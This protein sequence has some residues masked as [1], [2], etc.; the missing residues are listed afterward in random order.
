VSI[1]K[2]LVS[3]FLRPSLAELQITV[4]DTVVCEY[5]LL[6]HYCLL[7]KSM[8]SESLDATSL[9]VVAQC[10]TMDRPLLRLTHDDYTVACICPMGVE[11]APVE[12]MLD[13]MHQSLPASRDKNSYTLGRIGAHNVVIAV[14]PEIG[15]N[16]AAIVATQLL[17]DFTSIRFGLLVG[18]GGGIPGDDE[19]DIR[20]GDVVVSKP[21]ATFGGVVQFD[22]GK[23]HPNGQF[24][25]TGTL[26]KPPAVL[27]ANVQRLEAQ[28][29]RIGNQISKYL[30]EMLERFPNMEEEYLHP[31]M[32]HDQLFEATYSHKGRKTCRQ[33]DWSRVVERAPRRNSVPRIHYGTIGSANEVIKDSETRDK[34]RKDLGILCV[35]M[36]AAGLMDEFSCLVIRGICDYADSHKNKAWQPYA[37]A[38]AAAYAKELL[39]IIP[40]QEIVVTTKA[41]DALRGTPDL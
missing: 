11:L 40:A 13:E 31:G 26:K 8:L 10:S 24:E 12:A 18:I 33:C 32:E 19:D 36:E 30:S 25:R 20:L 35:E 21:T 22:R 29:R 38:T 4:A 34:L 37:A 23:I 14:M 41:V 39:S 27:M 17:N 6:M 7:L 3:S 1:I 2:H 16:N 15:N 28:H 9:V 5:L